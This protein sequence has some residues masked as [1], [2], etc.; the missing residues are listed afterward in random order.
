MQTCSPSKVQ[1]FYNQR[2]RNKCG[3]KRIINNIDIY[4]Q[5]K[6]LFLKEQWSTEEIAARMRLEINWTVISYKTIYRTIYRGDFDESNLY[7]GN[8]SAVRKLRHRRKT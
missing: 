3:R 4:I 1:K 2:K 7:R 6:R 5:V 8:R